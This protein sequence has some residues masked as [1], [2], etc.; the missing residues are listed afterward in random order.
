MA[1]AFMFAGVLYLFL[2]LTFDITSEIALYRRVR[3]GKTIILYGLKKAILLEKETRA[4]QHCISAFL[5]IGGLI[6]SA[7]ALFVQTSAELWLTIA[8]TIPH[9]VGLLLLGYWTCVLRFDKNFIVVSPYSRSRFLANLLVF[10][11]IYPFFIGLLGFV[12]SRESVQIILD[13]FIS[14]SF[15]LTVLVITFPLI[16]GECLFG[17]ATLTELIPFNLTNPVYLGLFLIIS[18]IFYSHMH[19]YSIIHIGCSDRIHC[20]PIFHAILNWEENI[21]ILTR[22]RRLLLSVVESAGLS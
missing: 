10:L 5:S 20:L 12:F 17:V 18:L 11:V 16:L 7:F 13:A 1:D 4:Y 9:A 3:L 15:L 6:Y 14:I 22:S 21:L 19:I 2:G 8:G